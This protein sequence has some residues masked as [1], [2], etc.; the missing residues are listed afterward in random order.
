VPFSLEKP[1][2]DFQLNTLNVFKILDAIRRFNSGCKY[3]SLSSAAVYGNPQTLPI[4][5]THPLAPVSPYGIHKMMA[6]QICEEF[7]RFWNVKT[8]CIRIFSA[9]GPGLKKQLLWDISQKLKDEGPLSLFG[10]GRETRDFIHIDDLVN[11]I[12]VVIRKAQ[13]QGD[14]INAAN[15][16]ETSIREI[17]ECMVDEIAPGREIIFSQSN[18][19]GDPLNWVADISKATQLGYV[20]NINIKRGINSYI[21]WLRENELL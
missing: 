9:Y 10:T 15:G 1:F 2:H 6:E 11:L 18:R 12:D 13:F 21:S 3:L 14:F 7:Y 4:H 5:E 20:Q 17:A 16:V 19:R 8:C